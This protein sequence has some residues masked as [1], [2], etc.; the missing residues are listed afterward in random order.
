[1]D[2]KEQAAGAA[3]VRQLLIEP[4]VRLGLAAKCVGLSRWALEQAAD[5]H[6]LME[7]GKH[8]GKIM[9]TA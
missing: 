3:R 5:A 8:I 6:R 1:M 7:S 2:A 9:L 4:L